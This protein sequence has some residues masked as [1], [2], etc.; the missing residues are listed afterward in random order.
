MNKNKV[1]L[2]AGG[3]LRQVYLSE[4]L[5]RENKVYAI[6]FDKKIITSDKIIVI[7]SL[8]SIEERIDYI[9]LPL[10]ASNDGVMVNSPFF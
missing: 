9:I 3:D 8:M 5:S 7:D 10:P 6:G 4:I 1:I 2:V